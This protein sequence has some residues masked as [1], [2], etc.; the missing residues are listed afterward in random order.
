MFVICLLYGY[1]LSVYLLFGYVL[2]AYILYRGLLYRRF[3]RR[4]IFG[5][6]SRPQPGDRQKPPHPRP[7]GGSAG[8]RRRGKCYYSQ[9]MHFPK[10]TALI[11]SKMHK[12]YIQS[13][14]NIYKYKKVVKFTT[15]FLPVWAAL[16]L[17]GQTARKTHGQRRAYSTQNAG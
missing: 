6:L 5:G 11:H 17:P 12:L 16:P 14:G 15:F 10:S 13:I 7:P 1:I 2:C 9:D 8:P 3:F 4:G